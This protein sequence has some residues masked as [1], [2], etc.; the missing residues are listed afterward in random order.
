MAEKYVCCHCNYTGTE[1]EFD[2]RLVAMRTL[3]TPSEYEW[4]CP[5]CRNTDVDEYQPP[6]CRHCEDEQVQHEGELCPECYAEEV[7]RHIDASRGH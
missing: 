6:M 1:D 3:E 7:E 5:Q 4:V 2:V